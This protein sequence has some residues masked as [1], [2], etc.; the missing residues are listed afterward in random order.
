[1]AKPLHQNRQGGTALGW[2]PFLKT[3]STRFFGV[4]PSFTTE[5]AE[6][7]GWVEV[8]NPAISAGFRTST[9]PTHSVP[10]RA[11]FAAVSE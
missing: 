10:L 1:M 2:P 6:P 7:V 8:R 9:Q 4:S 11:S 3:A 5:N